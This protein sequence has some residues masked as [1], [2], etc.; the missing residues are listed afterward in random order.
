[1]GLIYCGALSSIKVVTG[2]MEIYSFEVMEVTL[3]L[4]LPTF[5]MAIVYGHL[6]G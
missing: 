5:R 2:S 3:N 6:Y 1:M 4:C